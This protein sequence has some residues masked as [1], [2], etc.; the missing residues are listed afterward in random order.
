MFVSTFVVIFFELVVKR[1]FKA[2]VEVMENYFAGMVKVFPAVS[3]IVCAGFFADGL[4]AIGAVEMLVNASTALGFGGLAVT[5]LMAFVIAFLAVLLGSGNAAFLSIIKLVPNI[6]TNFGITSLTKMIVPLNLVAGIG[7][8]VSPIAAV[9][10]AC[11]DIA[12]VSP[13]DAIKRSSVPMAAGFI[14]I[15][16]TSFLFL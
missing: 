16:V 9:V 14:T 5:I 6:A 7:R 11:C 4:I 12:Q 2:I 10:I 13:F 3:L 15:L 1:K 8:S